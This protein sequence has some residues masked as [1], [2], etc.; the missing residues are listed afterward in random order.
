MSSICRITRIFP[1]TRIHLTPFAC[2]PW[3]EMALALFY[4]HPLTPCYSLHP[5]P[6]ASS[7]LHHASACTA[8]SLSSA[9]AD[10]LPASCAASIRSMRLVTTLFIIIALS[11]RLP[12][13]DNKSTVVS[14][15]VFQRQ[16]SELLENAHQGD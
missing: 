8:G 10:A 1:L 6:H 9:T 14:C 3:S 16:L 15:M 5:I 7:Y 13:A 4:L 11:C 2:A 12:Q